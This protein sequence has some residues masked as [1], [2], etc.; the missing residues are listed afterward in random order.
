MLTRRTLLTTGA[1]VAALLALRPLPG[2]AQDAATAGATQFVQQTAAQIVGIINGPGN[3]AEK[4]RQIAPIV[5]Q[6][7]DVNGVGRFCLGR[8]W[9]TASPQEQQEYLQLFHSV[10]LNSVTGR[11]GDYHGVA[12]TVGRAEQRAD[13][14]YVSSVLNRPGSAPSN[15]IWVV[16]EVGGQP[17][18][19]DVIAEGTSLRLTQRSDYASYLQQHGNNVAALISALRSQLAQG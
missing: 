10:L 15:V 12:V 16:N 7:V 18:I 19:V 8:F 9:R 14:T 1:A 2:F 13:G 3:E 4:Q 6:T 17:K 11:L 5:D